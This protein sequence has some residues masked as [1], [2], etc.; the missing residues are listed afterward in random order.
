[1]SHTSLKSYIDTVFTIMQ[2]YKW[3]INF[4]DSR[5]PWE[6]EVMLLKIIEWQKKVSNQSSG[7]SLDEIFGYDGDNNPGLLFNPNKEIR[8]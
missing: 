3:D 4:F 7:N 8:R 5:M 2:D 6:V 1:M